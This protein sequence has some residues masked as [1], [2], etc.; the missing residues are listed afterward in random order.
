MT[1]NHKAIENL[2]TTGRTYERADRDGLSLRVSPTGQKSFQY[3]Y[4]HH[5]QQHRLRYGAFPE[6]SLKEARE[7]HTK[8]RALLEK[9]IDPITHARAQAA[10]EQNVPT[11]A[12]L[13]DRWM[14]GYARPQRRRPEIPAQMIDADIKPRL[15]QHKLADLTRRMIVTDLLDPILKRGSPVQANKTLKLIKQILDYGVAQGYLDVNPAQLIN[16]RS[17][18]GTGDGFTDPR[19]GSGDDDDSI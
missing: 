4:R 13:C 14:S 5:G 12:D 2:P 7:Q 3:R 10:A 18:G 17:V 15:G 11:V 19:P 6:P 1:L 8:S 9:G 16:A